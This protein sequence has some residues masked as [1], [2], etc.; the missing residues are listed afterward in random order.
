MT[1]DAVD[2]LSFQPE[3]KVC[4]VSLAKV[5][6][7][8][9]WQPS[10]RAGALDTAPAAVAGMAVSA[11]PAMSVSAPFGLEP[12]PP[13]ILGEHER[14]YLAGFLAGI[15]S[16]I[17]G[18]PVL[19]PGA[20]FSREHALWVNGM[21][22]GMY[23]RAMSAPP[24]AYGSGGSP[25]SPAPAAGAPRRQVMVLWASQTGN[26]EEFATAAA[27]RL[28]AEG[29]PVSLLPMDEADP[30]ALPSDAELLLVTSTFGDGDAPDNGA[31]FWDALASPGAPRLQGRRYAVLA[32]G[33]SS[34][35]NFCGH[36]RRLDRR[37]EELG[38]VRLAPR[39]DCEP[40]Y[41]T[42]AG[43]WLEQVL[44]VLE[45]T[46]RPACGG[47]VPVPAAAAPAVPRPTRPA[48]ATAR[49]TGNRLLA[50]PVRARRSGASPSTPATATPRWSTRPATPWRCTQSTRRTS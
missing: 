27:G 31:G 12:A 7:P 33:D 5:A 39:T 44:A 13:P 8:V 3:F 18:V 48:P 14:L 15:P 17:P 41:E 35:G 16:G 50:G 23:S 24:A 43:A 22:A 26:A 19:P 47:P 10:A 32:F 29:H 40:D 49:L 20:P 11:Q 6:T 2:P 38:A 45:S 37:M 25:R 36:G 46:E 28:T 1:S 34:Y 30:A 21:L 4:A 42:E 9:T